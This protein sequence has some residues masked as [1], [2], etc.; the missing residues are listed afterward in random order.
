M[1]WPGS[2]DVTIRRFLGRNP[3]RIFRNP[4]SCC[5]SEPRE[6]IN[7]KKGAVLALWPGHIPTFQMESLYSL[8]IITPFKKYIQLMLHQQLSA[9]RIDGLS[10]ETAMIL[11]KLS[12]LARKGKSLG[13][14]L[15]QNY[16]QLK[17]VYRLNIT[18]TTLH[19]RGQSMVGLGIRPMSVNFF[20]TSMI[21]NRKKVRNPYLN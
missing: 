20:R 12:M 8:C 13:T 3:E 15:F 4:A 10:K 2:P 5:L 21:L 14:Y 1:R 17:N 18:H 9:I 7:W 11:I 6:I 16:L 19:Y